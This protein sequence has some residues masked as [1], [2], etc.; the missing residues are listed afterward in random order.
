MRP[1]LHEIADLAS[2]SPATV[3]RV[4][5]ERP[6]VATSPRRRVLDAAERLGLRRQTS[7]AGVIGVIT[8]ELDNPAFSLHAHTI[9]NRL[10]RLGLLPVVCVATV[11]AVQEAAYLEHLL[12]IGVAGLVVVSGRYA[13][14]GASLALYEPVRR[15]GVPTVLVNGVDGDAMF[16]AVCVDERAATDLAVSHL[17]S[18]GHDRIACLA[19]QRRYRSSELKAQGWEAAT[20]GAWPEL[21]VETP[22][23]VEGGH[24]GAEELLSRGATAIACANDLMAL[25]AIRAVR[26]RG[27]RVPDDVSIVGY[28][29]TPIT[30]FTDPALTTVRQPFERMAAAV[31]E[32]LT[33]GD[34]APNVQLFSPELVVRAS[35]GASPRVPG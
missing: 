33:A 29:G 30:Q 28:D 23:T 13:E 7:S 19:G 27:G 2:V 1:R 25:G 8:P 24:A 34:H 11:Q 21:I 10:A 6:G 31:T 15:A 22:F 16:P 5:N 32:L 14:T 4:L 18:L 35:S 26:D 17:R 12:D 3:S 20:G 9:E